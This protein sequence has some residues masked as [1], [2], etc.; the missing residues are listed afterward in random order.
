[1]NA[2]IA[3][4]PAV[5]PSAIDLRNPHLPRLAWPTRKPNPKQVRRK[6]QRAL[7][8][9]APLQLG[10]LER[11]FEARDEGHR[12]LRWLEGQLEQRAGHSLRLVTA[13]PD[14]VGNRAR[15]ARLDRDHAIEIDIATTHALNASQLAALRQ[16]SQCGLAVRLGLP[17]ALQGRSTANLSALVAAAVDHGAH[18]VVVG[19]PASRR[20]YGVSDAQLR[21]TVRYLRLLH[22]L[23]RA[24]PG[25]G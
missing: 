12:L 9:G 18:D 14:L 21:D 25:R 10:S 13:G 11:P 20:A 4:R 23:P 3:I 22:G 6:L 17:A 16:L 15:L 5:L 19:P 8:D 24:L 1:M 2:T 7:A